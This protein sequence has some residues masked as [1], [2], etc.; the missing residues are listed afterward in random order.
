MHYFDPVPLLCEDQMKICSA[1]TDDG[2][3]VLYDYGHYT[4]EGAKMIGERLVQKQF[5]ELLK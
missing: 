3:K 1:F 4:L 5:G 2:Y